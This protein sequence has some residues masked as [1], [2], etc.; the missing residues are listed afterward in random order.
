MISD[1]EVALT[2]K[3]LSADYKKLM[4]AIRCQQRIFRRY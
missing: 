3:P 1:P 4:I 2:I